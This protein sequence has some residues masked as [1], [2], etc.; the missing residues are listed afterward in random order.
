MRMWMVNPQILCKNHLLG[1]HRE[2]HTCVGLL[3]KG[4]SMK[5]YFKNNLFEPL[6][7]MNRHDEIVKEL[8]VRGYNHH[9]PILD[10]I[11]EIVRYLPTEL[12][13]T[14]VDSVDSL[15]NLLNRCEKC[16]ERYVSIT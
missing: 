3:R 9:T 12:I 14:K 16:K 2:L 15:S 4:V 5:N 7:L 10:N 1:E 6:S 11:S 8:Y 13:S